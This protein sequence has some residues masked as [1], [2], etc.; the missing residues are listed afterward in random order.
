[1]TKYIFTL[2][3]FFAL[4]G[5]SSAQWTTVCGTGNGF[6]DNFEVFNSELYAT[7]FFNTLCGTANNHIVKWDGS[8]WQPVGT[9]SPNAGH[10]LKYL[11]NHLY[12]VGYEPTITD[13]NWV[14]RFDGSNF[15]R[16]GEGVYLTNAI[17]GGSQTVNLYALEEFNGNVIA[18]GEFNRVGNKAISGIMQ[19][20]GSSWDSLGSGLSG[21]IG[22][23]PIMYPHDLCHL[24]TDLIVAG[25]FLKAGGITVNGI[26]RWD[27]S[28]WHNLGSGF[29][30]TVY[31]ICVF[32]GEL[33]AGGDFT[34]SGSTPLK[35]IA[36]WNG[37]AWVDP[38]FRMYYNNST[39]YSFVHTLK[40]FNSKLYIAGGFDRVVEGSTVHLGQGICAFD[41]TN[42]DTLS[43]G[44]LNREIEGIAYYNGEIYAGGGINNSNSYIAKYTNTAS[45]DELEEQISWI[46]Q[47][48]PAE[49]TCTVSGIEKGA[50]ISILSLDGKV[51]KT[52][53]ANGSETSIDLSSLEA[54]VY[55]VKI[56]DKQRRLVKK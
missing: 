17:S 13:S 29:N 18:C 5:N 19:W 4:T 46:I 22:T 50:I 38:G 25:N 45:L 56:G 8:V 28:Q 14:Y 52:V 15:N 11:G 37:T 42:I 54:G 51:C 31:G 49:N 3:L 39:Y 21:N 47:P 30:S 12:F 23:A 10:Q 20:D 7:G 2:A 1:M 34:M 26:A 55:L 48:N 33:Y 40:V 6:V 24:G 41:G 27:G 44:I 9:G 32:N 36:K 43:G 53:W 35:C 16:L